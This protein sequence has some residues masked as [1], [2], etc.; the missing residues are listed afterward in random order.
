PTTPARRQGRDLADVQSYKPNGFGLY[1]VHG[2]AWEWV[3]DCWTERLG[4]EKANSG[5]SGPGPG[6]TAETCSRVARGGSWRS[7][8]DALR[9]AKRVPFPQDHTRVT[10]GFRIVRVLAKSEVVAAK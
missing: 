7:A 8:P 4:S 6:Q 2:N 10:L 9:L 5:A 1:D 3:A